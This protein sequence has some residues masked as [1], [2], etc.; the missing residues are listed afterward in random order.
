MSN[1][2]SLPGPPIAWTRPD[3]LVLT[4]L[5]LFLCMY[6][7]VPVCLYVHYVLVVPTEAGRGHQIPWIWTRGG[8]ELPDEGSGN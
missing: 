7:R 3:D 4:I 8:C 2:P 6:M 1:S 5:N